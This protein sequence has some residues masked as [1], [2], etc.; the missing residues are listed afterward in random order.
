MLQFKKPKKKK[1]LRK[2]EKFDVEALEAEAKTTGLGA[3]D[4]GSKKDQSPLATKIEEM[5]RIKQTDRK[6]TRG[7]T[8]RKQLATKA[9]CK[10]APTTGGVKKPHHYR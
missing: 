7:K 2:K 3:S 4:L 9:A 1:S 10:S 8:P 6:S 5:A